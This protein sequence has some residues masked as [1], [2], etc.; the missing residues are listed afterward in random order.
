V[1][2]YEQV[3]ICTINIV[4]SMYTDAYHIWFNNRAVGQSPSLGRPDIPYTSPQT[5]WQHNRVV[6]QSNSSWSRKGI[7]DTGPVYAEG[8]D[9]TVNPFQTE[10]TLIGYSG[11]TNYLA[12]A[13]VMAICAGGMV[14]FL[15]ALS[16]T[17]W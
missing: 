8:F 7:H 4:T 16:R 1:L 11:G 10:P 5:S 9:R 2:Q 17:M 15:Y 14:L 3:Y 6:G 13:A 12:C